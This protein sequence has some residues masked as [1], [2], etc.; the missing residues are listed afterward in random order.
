ML[1]SKTPAKL[2]KNLGKMYSKGSKY[3]IQKELKSEFNN[4][5]IENNNN[6]KFSIKLFNE[7]F[8]IISIL[9]IIFIIFVYILL[10]LFHFILF[11]QTHIQP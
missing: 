9:K 11:F 5:S 7:K 2:I 8:L 3:L 4:N 6:N 10:T 1:Y